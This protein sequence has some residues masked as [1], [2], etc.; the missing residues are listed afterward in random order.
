[1]IFLTKDG[2]TRFSITDSLPAGCIEIT[3]DGLPVIAGAPTAATLAAAAVAPAPPKK[4]YYSA[5]EL[6]AA[7]ARRKF[8]A[9]SEQ[10]RVESLAAAAKNKK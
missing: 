4:M 7:E 6:H 2:E 8:E 3:P 9:A 5:A 1:M 10:A